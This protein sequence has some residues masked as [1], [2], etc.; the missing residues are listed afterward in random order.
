MISQNNQ[1]TRCLFTFAKSLLNKNEFIHEMSMILQ[2]PKVIKKF[3]CKFY[4]VVKED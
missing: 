4:V 3:S 2:T 1:L